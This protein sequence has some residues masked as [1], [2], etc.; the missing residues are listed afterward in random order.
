MILAG[1]SPGSRF[2]FQV[3]F[4]DVSGYHATLAGEDPCARIKRRFNELN[5]NQYFDTVFITKL[6]Q[7]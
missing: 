5:S 2:S 6:A 3:D 4:H 1:N 7:Y